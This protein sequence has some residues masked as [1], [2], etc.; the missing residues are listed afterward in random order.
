VK[1]KHLPVNPFSAYCLENPV[2][3][4]RVDL[5]ISLAGKS[6]RTKDDFEGRQNNREKQ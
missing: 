2:F 3:P 5:N 1:R 4:P 6:A